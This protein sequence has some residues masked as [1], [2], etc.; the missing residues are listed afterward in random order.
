MKAVLCNEFIGPAG[1]S[2]GEAPPPPM[3]ADELRIAVRCA[4]VTFMDTL[5][6]SGLYQMKPPLPFVPG[7]DAAGE[8]MEVGA[9]VTRFKV[10]D[11]VAA[12]AWTGAFAGQMVVKDLRA[13]MLPDALDYERG[14]AIMHCYV[15]A[16]YALRERAALAAGETL[17]VHGA[18]G[19]VGL[20]AVELGR[21]LGARV[22]ATVGSDEKM[23]I[24]KQYGAEEVINH[25]KDDFRERVK[26]L[27]GGRGA[28]VIC[29]PVGGDVFDQ[30]VRCIAWNGRL[31][32]IGFA[33]GRIPELAVNRVLLNN[34]SVVGVMTGVW[35]DR[36]PQD[37][38]RVS[39]EVMALA[40]SGAINPLVSQT[41]PMEEVGDAMRAIA[42]RGVTGRIVINIK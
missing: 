21:H 18:A 19:G 33:S 12:F 34:F 27:T 29:D 30:S 14:A 36:Y 16:L 25:V 23:A 13:I 17:L 6:V 31:L 8:V 10:G 32:V 28:D 26:E 42:G 9:E 37:N 24:V 39:D 35:A 5:L 3:A 15:T 11:R 40:A 22:I 41:L 1:L 20:A 4:S 7:T 2:V 38:I